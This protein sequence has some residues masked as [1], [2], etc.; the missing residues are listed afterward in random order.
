[1]G[2][3]ADW[4]R[5]TGK[6][7]ARAAGK[8]IA[9][10]GLAYAKDALGAGVRAELEG[11]QSGEQSGDGVEDWLKDTGREVARA[12]GSHLKSMARDKAVALAKQH[13]GAGIAEVKKNS[14]ILELLR[15]SLGVDHGY[16]PA[17]WEK[18]WKENEGR[19]RDVP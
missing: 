7:I 16:D 1:M 14:K 13:L 2:E 8:H 18:W 9:E 6:D 12:V 11:E 10:R 15:D 3:L 4:L 5:N 17:A 19:F